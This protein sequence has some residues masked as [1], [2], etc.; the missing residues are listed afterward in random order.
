MPTGSCAKED[1]NDE[2]LRFVA[3]WKERTGHLPEELIFDS[4]LTTYAHLNKLNQ[5]GIAFITLR[6]RSEKMI[7]G[8]HQEPLSAWRRIELKGVSRL[9]KTPRILD[10]RSNWVGIT[11][12]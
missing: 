11:G 5:M 3:F 4:R 10:R 1:Q 8:I 12:S 6:R 2:I 9:Y 7:H